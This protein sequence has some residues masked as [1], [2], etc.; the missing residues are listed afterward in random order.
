MRGRSRGHEAINAVAAAIDL[1]NP[2]AMCGRKCLRSHAA[3][4]E[5]R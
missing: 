5:K 3:A 2:P 1:A 4:Y